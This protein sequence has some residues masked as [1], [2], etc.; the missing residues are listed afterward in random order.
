MNMQFITR[1]Q[2][3][4]LGLAF[5][6]CL[7]TPGVAEAATFTW[8]VTTGVWQTAGS[9]LNG[10]V[11][12]DSTSTDTALFSGA[13][14]SQ[15]A[16]LNANRSI[17]G[18]TFSGAGTKSI[19]SDSTTARVLTIGGSGITANADSGAITLGNAT[20]PLNLEIS[21]GQSWTNNSSSLLSVLG[22]VQIGRAH[23]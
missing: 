21:A 18:L 10:T 14:G 11:P 22:T 20:N 3:I 5:I 16:T 12:A 9:W 6:A 8:N 13:S 4:L 1:C 23:V 17:A 2:K 19:T 15:T 7:A